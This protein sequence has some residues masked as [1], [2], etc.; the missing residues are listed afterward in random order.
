[1][2]LKARSNTNARARGPLARSGGAA[3]VR[4]LLLLTLGAG[5]AGFLW[6]DLG[7]FLSL[8]Y[9]S[10]VRT[11]AAAAV[12]ASPVLA[13]GLFLV[14]YVAV[15]ALSLPGAAVMTLAGGALFGLAW[16]L[17]LVSFASS[18]GATL[19]MLISRSL[20]RDWVQRRFGLQLESVNRGLQ[21]DGGF[22]LFSLR[23]VPLFPFFV[24][25][26]VMGLTPIR[27]WTFYWV[28]Q[29]GMLAGTT[30]YVFAGTQLGRIAS[31]GDILSPGLIV[32]FS[33]L[34]L[35]PLVARKSM[36]WLRA[37]RAQRH[38]ES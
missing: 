10:A 34:G 32:A 13:S 1:M 29:A 28:S 15:T 38:E 20:L 30:V 19:A 31:P 8:E 12:A 26:L 4:I 23:M 36:T 16:G 2:V 37:R 35:F 3:A 7:R 24:V 27:T 11:D 17:V 33:L 22:Y 21:A 25:N 14:V 9:L 6:F 5:I 18:V